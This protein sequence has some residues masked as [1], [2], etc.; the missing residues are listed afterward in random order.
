MIKSDTINY[1]NNSEIIWRIE[2]PFDS[3]YSLA[4]LNREIARALQKQGVKVV[5]FSTEGPGDF[6]PSPSFL[7][8]NQDLAQMSALSNTID[9]NEASVVSRNLYPPRVADM[10]C[11]INIMHSYAWEETNY[12]FAWTKNFNLYLSG[13]TCLSEH[14]KKTMRDNGVS[15]RMIV[16]GCGVDH[17]ERVIPASTS[18]IDDIP[19]KSFRFLHVSSFFPRKGPD[20]LLEAWAHSFSAKQDVCLVIKTFSNPHNRIH[21]QI[22]ELKEKFPSC[23]PIYVI[24]DDMSDA[25]LKAL[26]QRCHVLV[27]PSCAEGFC[28]PIAEAMLSGIPAITTGWSGQLDF[29]NNENSWLVDYD[30]EQTDTHFEL[31]PS[32]WAAVKTDA[33]STAMQLAFKTSPEDRLAMAQR[34]RELL[35]SNFCWSHVAE[36][37]IKL[38]QNLNIK[39]TLP[40]S[41]VGWISTWN[42]K[43]GIATYSKHLMNGFKRHPHVLAARSE[44]VLEV[45]DED[46]TRCWEASDKDDLFDLASVVKARNLDILVIQWNFGFFHHDH[47]F[48]FVADQKAANKVIIIE[49]H[50]TIDPPQST[51]KKMS[52]YLPTLALADRILVHSILD[53]NRMKSLGL[54]NNIALFPHGILDKPLPTASNLEHPTI[55]TY[56]FCLPHKGLE[57]VIEA[58]ALLRDK[59]DR[60][61]LRLVNAEYPVDFS[62]DLARQLRTKINTL[63]LQNQVMI[64][65][66]FLE[67]SE[68]LKLLQEVDLV[69]FAYSPTSESVSGAVRYGIASGKPVMVTALPIFSEFG[70]S[71]WI[72]EDNSPATLAESIRDALTHIRSDSKVHQDK[73]TNAKNWRSQHSYNLISERLEGMIDGLFSDNFFGD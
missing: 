34:G 40:E 24:E 44:N 32:S 61:D 64:E 57:Q 17:W 55:A 66:S 28:L 38:Y 36:R 54:V 21:E 25:D 33:L 48:K 6:V 16:S 20:A 27:A 39:S 8:A 29:C 2:G 63:G 13:L 49:L 59:G 62:A 5:L 37:L 72:A 35:L 60:V 14:V 4:L 68:S 58:I 9:H 15:V 3:S 51:N 43:C 30:F 46:C 53:M 1:P 52:D 69:L 12:P 67:D 42:T 70:N 31:K 47:L 41:S 50:S 45:D 71:V 65:T 22:K 7:S 19:T 18:I 73:Q 56:G 10:R 23:A 26:Y 11:H